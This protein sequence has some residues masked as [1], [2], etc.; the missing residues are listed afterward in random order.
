VWGEG[1]R[2]ENEVEQ[3]DWSRVFVKPADSKFLAISP[4]LPSFLGPLLAF[5]FVCLFSLGFPRHYSSSFP[6]DDLSL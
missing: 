5:L 2:N 4:S 1:D 3:K 6:P